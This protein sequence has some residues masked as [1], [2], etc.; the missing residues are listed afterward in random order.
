MTLTYATF[1]PKAYVCASCVVSA[2]TQRTLEKR[3]RTCGDPACVV[4]ESSRTCE[5]K[6]EYDDSGTSS[7]TKGQ[8]AQG[9][10]RGA[11]NAFLDHGVVRRSHDELDGVPNHDCTEQC[12]QDP[13]HK[14]RL[15]KGAGNADDAGPYPAI[16]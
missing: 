15:L 6:L 1:P 9:L 8:L 16:D 3:I 2:A 13:Q 11:R 5:K 4:A 14:A 10:V 7:L 12:N